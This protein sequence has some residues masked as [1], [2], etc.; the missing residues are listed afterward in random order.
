MCKCSDLVI[1]NG[2]TSGDREGKF[3]YIDKK[4]K[5]VIDLA[6]VSKE[7]LYLVKSF[8]VWEPNVHSDY[9]L[10][11]LSL[12]CNVL[13]DM[14]VINEISCTHRE[15]NT[16]TRTKWKPDA[17]D[18]FVNLMNEEESMNKLNSI[19]DCLDD[20]TCEL[21][22]SNCL[23]KLDEVVKYASRSHV[24]KVSQANS[25]PNQSVKQERWYDITCREKKV[26]FDIARWLALT[27]L[28]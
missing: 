22:L 10:I 19:M 9:V 6:A 17:R 13:H 14:F 28:Y 25:S 20:N 4:G 16:L 3:T 2:R 23:S 24:S 26:D 11:S 12:K 5:S 18:E 21:N 15:C 8:K 7:I 27:G 1:L